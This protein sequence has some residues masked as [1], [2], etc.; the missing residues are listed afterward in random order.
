VIWVGH[1]WVRRM[2]IGAGL[3]VEAAFRVPSSAAGG[4]KAALNAA[5][6][7]AVKYGLA[8]GFYLTI[9]KRSVRIGEPT[10]TLSISAWV[11]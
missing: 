3:G 7:D 1:S 8:R 9:K 5:T 10:L 4:A 2:S 6:E 11:N